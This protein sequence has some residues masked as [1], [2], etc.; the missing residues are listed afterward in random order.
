MVCLVICTKPADMI[1]GIAGP[2]SAATEAERQQNLDKLNLAAARLLEMGHVPLI[3]VNAAIPV[4]AAANVTDKYE[5]IMRISMA[6]MQ[7]CEAL[8]LTAESPGALR[9]RDD[10]TARGLPVYY[11]IDEVPV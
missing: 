11:S 8:L 6:V 9:E 7:P 2:Y 10:F 4:V 1:I 3:G 5:A